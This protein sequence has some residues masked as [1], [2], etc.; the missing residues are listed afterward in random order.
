MYRWKMSLGAVYRNDLANLL[1]QRLGIEVVATPHGFELAAVPSR[2]ITGFSKRSQAIRRELVRTGRFSAK[3]AALATLNTRQRKQPFRCDSLFQAWREAAGR[4]GISYDESS[5]FDKQTT[6]N[7]LSPGDLESQLQQAIGRL[8]ESQ[9]HFTLREILREVTPKLM[10]LG[11][12]SA[13]IVSA[14]DQHLH[15]SK[16]ILHLQELGCE[17]QYTTRQVIASETELLTRCDQLQATS[18]FAV[19]KDIADR[20]LR[21]H[22]GVQSRP[23]QVQA[24][25]HLIGEGS[26]KLLSG[27]PGT[28]KTHVLN[29]ARTA[30]EK[31]GFKVMGTSLAGRA[32]RGLET[33]AGIQSDTIAKL[34]ADLEATPFDSIKHDARQLARAALGRPTYAQNRLRLDA[35]TILVVDEAGMVDTVTLGRL[36]R[37]VTDA[38]AKIVLVGDPQQLPAIAAGGP[39]RVLLNRQEAVRLS[40]IERQKD[41]RDVAAIQAFSRGD[42]EAAVR[43]YQQRGLIAVEADRKQ[44]VHRL[45]ADWTKHGG[46]EHPEQHAILVSTNADGLLLNDLC[47]KQ[48]LDAGHLSTESYV[49]IRRRQDVEG[50]GELIVREDLHVGDRVMC[51][52]RS[53]SL[54]LENGQFG[55]I[56]HY[57]RE[58]NAVTLRL[59]DRN[60]RHRDIVVPINTYPHLTLGYAGTTH[61]FQGA[62]VD[63]SY[64]LIGGSM[65][66]R[67]MTFTQLTRARFETRLYADSLDAGDDL[68]GLIA[69]IERSQAKRLAH[70]LLPAEGTSGG[71]APQPHAHSSHSSRMLAALA[72]APRPQRDVY[73]RPSSLDMP[74]P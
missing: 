51:T 67:E 38:G 30:W 45:V 43:S 17:R 4:L 74:G 14:V 54:G 70:E 47:Q 58:A 39:F 73:V 20:V 9:S 26:F 29:V 23:E 62:T 5:R 60:A 21:T 40:N 48:R 31:A 46:V 1:R 64:V 72:T 25:W 66:S 33:Q 52:K 13:E 6:A 19:P 18:A 42:I 11:V 53:R 22:P 28:G 35:T 65:Q 34:L 3:A 24:Y 50:I 68:K 36:I 69:Q 55:M 59:D 44:A 56:S 63:H 61:K 27:D 41:A 37:H 15:R 8:T 16:D 57:D 49:T 71:L 12:S 2:A 10:G 32:V 7:K